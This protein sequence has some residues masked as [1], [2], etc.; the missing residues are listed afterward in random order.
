MR[1]HGYAAFFVDNYLVPICSSIWST[2]GAAILE[3]DAPTLLRFLRNHQMLQVFGRPQWLT[4]A[5]RSV[6]YTAA[7]RAAVEARGGVFVL[8]ERVAKVAGATHERGAVVTLSTGATALFDAVVV[9]AHA[10]DAAALLSGAGAAD[11]QAVL[12]AFGYST[13]R[14]FL[15][16][17]AELMPKARAAW[18]AWNF[19]GGGGC[20][21]HR[22]C[23]GDT[24]FLQPN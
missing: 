6:T 19:L 23:G 10:P 17:D 4:V 20:V 24:P 11:A 13:S 5:G 16:R 3:C 12:G 21:A 9:A 14:V 1:A 18:S 8:N 2:P 7:V 15:H 22:L